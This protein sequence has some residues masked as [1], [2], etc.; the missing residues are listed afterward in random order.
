M[1]DHTKQRFADAVR[2]A[3]GARSQYAAAKQWSAWSGRSRQACA[4]AIHRAVRGDRIMRLDQAA[5]LAAALDL[6]PGELIPDLR[7]A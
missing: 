5:E 1:N 4:M 2:R 7:G 3:L 6:D